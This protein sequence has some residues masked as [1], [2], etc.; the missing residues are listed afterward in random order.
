MTGSPTTFIKA[1]TDDFDFNPGKFISGN[2]F[3]MN[4]NFSNQFATSNGEMGGVNPSDLTVS[5]GMMNNQ[6]GSQNMSNSFIADD[7]LL[8]LEGMDDPSTQFSNYHGFGNSN[9][10]NT[11]NTNGQPGNGQGFYHNHQGGGMNTQI[12]PNTPDTQPIASPF[13]GNFNYE[14]YRPS[15]PGQQGF[16]PNMAMQNGGYSMNARIRQSLERQPS[17]SRSPM[18]PRTPAM[19]GLQLTGTPDSGSMQAQAVMQSHLNHNAKMI[20]AQQWPGSGS[21]NSWEDDASLPSPQGRMQHPGIS[22]MIKHSSMPAKVE[23]G[24]L[25]PGFQS[26]EAKKK[27][28][29]ESHNAVERRRRDNI[30]ERIGDLSRLVPQHRLEDE[31]VRKHINNNGP[32]SPGLHASGMSPPQA[33]SLLA[34]GTGRRAAGNITQGLPMEEKDKGPNKGDILNG[35]VGWTR[36]LMWMLY[37]KY[38]QENDLKTYIESVGGTWPLEVTEDEKRMKTELIDAVEKNGADNFHY[39]RYNGSGLRVPKHTNYAGEP[40][41]PQQGLSPSVQGGGSGASANQPTQQQFWMHQSGARSNSGSF[42]LKEEDE[43]GMDIGT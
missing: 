30:N 20:A 17:D 43:Y 41:S 32:M 9:N 31:K 24:P 21:P 36:D 42:S 11:N 27:R 38:K 7:E 18:T 39:T 4:N 23:N 29:R 35:A 8:G 40:I 6:F 16:S 28:R 15:V 10:N 12:F 13:A 37:Q 26:Q 1:E 22:E 25:P 14:Q 19:N 33:T 2:G 3:G 5:G 34:G